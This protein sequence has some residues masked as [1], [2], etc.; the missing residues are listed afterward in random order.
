M[1]VDGVYLFVR[2]PM[3]IIAKRISDVFAV[4]SQ[5]NPA[6]TEMAYQFIYD[7]A[8]QRYEI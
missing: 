1:I 4:L 5:Q 2:I 7:I 8:L 3:L 6:K